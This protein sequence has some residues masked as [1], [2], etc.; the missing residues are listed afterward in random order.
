MENR[1]ILSEHR[2]SGVG[3]SGS[4]IRDTST[5]VQGMAGRTGLGLKE[6]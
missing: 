3:V 2:S 4:C 1:W 5:K 6:F